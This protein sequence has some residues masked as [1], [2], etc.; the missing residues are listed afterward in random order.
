M[1]TTAAEDRKDAAFEALAQAFKGAIALRK[2]IESDLAQE[3][4]V[5]LPV[6]VTNAPLFA[7]R[8]DDESRETLEPVGRSRIAFDSP[9]VRTSIVDLVTVDDL[10]SY[11]SDLADWLEA[12]PGILARRNLLRAAT[13]DGA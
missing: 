7:L 9:I 6:V 12:F 5:Y 4:H 2:L 13:R 3:E 8:Y 1:V 10:D 11:L